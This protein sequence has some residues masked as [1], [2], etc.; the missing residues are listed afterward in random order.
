MATNSEVLS[1]LIPNGGY[2]QIGDAY[3]GISFIDCEPLTE[4]QYKDGFA[5]FD[6]WEAD[7]K[8]NKAAAKQSAQAKLAAL[9]LTADEIAALGN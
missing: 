7:N 6:K 8:T 4:K 1:Y 3:E 2:V 5:Q 9:G